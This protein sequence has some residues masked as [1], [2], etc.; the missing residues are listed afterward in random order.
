MG[1]RNDGE[2]SELPPGNPRLGQTT[3][4]ISSLNEASFHTLGRCVIDT[5]LSENGHGG[6]LASDIAGFIM[7]EPQS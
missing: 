3:D 2:V 7:K 4:L 6:Q 5:L 1:L